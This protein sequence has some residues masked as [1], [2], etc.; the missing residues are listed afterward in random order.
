M[1]IQ[2]LIKPEN[3]D[4]VEGLELLARII[5]EGYMAGLNQSLKT[6]T[7]QEFSQYRSYQPGDDLRL[8]DW[9][10]FGRSDRYY[11]RQAE[12]DASINV[13]FVIDASASMNHKDNGITKLQYARLLAATLAYLAIRQG[14]A[15]GLICFSG[16]GLHSLVE[17]QGRQ[18]FL[19]FLYELIKIS[20][21]GSFPSSGG[22]GPLL[23]KGQR[24]VVF[25]LTDFFENDG[26]ILKILKLLKTR[27][28]E[29]IVLHL[30]GRNEVNFDYPGFTVFQDLETGEIVQTGTEK[31]EYQLELEKYLTGV[32]KSMVNLQISYE[33]FILDQDINKVLPLFLKKRTK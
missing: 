25:L 23:R 27:S 3:L 7:G 15:I 17:K 9:K 30:L 5:V 12:V 20:G 28:N 13:R 33:Q 2:S 29:V 18:H 24:E 21:L 26:E 22:V 1:S 6:G 31:H 19:R 8:L 11:I 14:D 10:M 4:S 16:Q 32:R